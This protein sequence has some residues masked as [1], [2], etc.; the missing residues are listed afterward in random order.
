MTDTGLIQAN[1][2]VTA[3][4]VVNNDKIHPRSPSLDPTPLKKQKR[5]KTKRYRE[6]P[7]DPISAEGV[8]INDIRALLKSQG[9]S[10]D[11]I[12]NDMKAFFSRDKSV[13]YPDYQVVELKISALS[14]VGNGI[15]IWES[16]DPEAPSSIRKRVVVVPYALVGETVKTKI[17]R[18]NKYYYESELNEVVDKSPLRDD[19]LVRCKYFTTCSGC[20]YQMLPYDEQLK[21]KREV[22]VNAYAHYAPLLTSDDVPSIL[23]TVGSPEQYN[24][25]TKLTPHFD[26]PR[27]GRLERIPPIGFGVK[28]RK[29]VLDIEECVI[30][31]PVINKGMVEQRKVV[32]EN[33]AS[34][35]RGA[36]ILLRE[37]IKEI[38]DSP[39]TVVC[40]T[41]SKEIVTEYVGDFKFKYPA[42]SFFQNNNSI[43]PS[44]TSYV[45]DNIVLPSSGKPPKYLVDTYCGSGL[46]G[47]TCSTAVE[48]L[49][50]VEIS[51]DSVEYAQKN[52]ELNNL[53][54]ASFIVGEAEKIFDKVSD[55]PLE[56]SI[57]IDPPRK[58]CDKQFLDQLLEF[59][60]AKVVY[61]SCNVHSQAR[62]IEYLLKSEV[63]RDRSS[64]SGNKYIID[65][66]RGFDFFPQTHHVESV[67]VLS[68]KNN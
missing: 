58:G 61:V 9:I 4:P 43:L 46:F 56:T 23:D 19:A 63:A 35:K 25:R 64:N 3:E 42:G 51:K 20:Q 29:E 32:H 38:E 40:T 59:R 45:R 2:K 39:S 57:I 17:Y 54:N 34:Y 22:I 1:S 31:T 12:T 33:F 14:S 60:P 21:I 52:A 27:K 47:I 10:E 36:T 15:G 65:S 8:L 11:E 66:I 30:G 48:Q 44:V 41:D 62:D 6:P 16:P 5:V 53:K 50:G 24:Y 26:V 13:P 67:A 68:L 28:G 7:V 55:A 37:N 18:T 49:I